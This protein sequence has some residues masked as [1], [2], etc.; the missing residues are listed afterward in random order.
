MQIGL[1]PT[2]ADLVLA[3]GLRR[4]RALPLLFLAALDLCFAFHAELGSD[5]E[6]VSSHEKSSRE[7]SRSTNKR[8]T[9][10]APERPRGFLGSYSAITSLEFGFGWEED[11]RPFIG[12]E[13]ET[14]WATRAAER[15]TDPKLATATAPRR[16]TI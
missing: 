10:S 5:S 3:L 8:R 15:P 7:K 1:S 9:F 2:Y 14:R 11:D 13:P 6:L 16:T 12:I 4:V